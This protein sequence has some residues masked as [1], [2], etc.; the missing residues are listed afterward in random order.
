M[1]IN[2]TRRDRHV[3]NPRD[4]IAFEKTI[5]IP[6]AIGFGGMGDRF[7]MISPPTK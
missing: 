6:I 1:G 5:R 7:D 2:R 3:N 4:C